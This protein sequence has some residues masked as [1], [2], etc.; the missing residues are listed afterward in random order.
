MQGQ[1]EIEALANDGD[2]HV[3]GDRDPDLRFDGV[4]GGAEEAVDA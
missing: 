4:L 1:I 2:Q 3:H